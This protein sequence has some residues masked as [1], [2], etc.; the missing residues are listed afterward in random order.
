MT[1]Y[2]GADW[3]ELYNLSVDPHETINLWD[4]PENSGQRTV[5]MEKLAYMMLDHIDT[6][7]YPSALA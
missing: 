5:M 3:G 2:D 4:V 1:I 7:P 6:S